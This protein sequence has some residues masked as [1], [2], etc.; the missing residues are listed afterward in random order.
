MDKQWSLVACLVMAL[1]GCA[2]KTSSAP[3]HVDLRQTITLHAGQNV[4]LK[5][6]QKA[7]APE[8]VTLSSGNG[9][10]KITGH[11][12]T[13]KGHTEVTVSVPIDATGP[14]DNL[15]IVMSAPS[16]GTLRA[17]A[18]PDA[19]GRDQ[20]LPESSGFQPSW[21]RIENSFYI[22][23][24]ND[25]EAVARLA[26][27]YYVEDVPEVPAS[28]SLA[29][30]P[31]YKKFLMRSFYADRSMITVFATQDALVIGTASLA[32]PPVSSG[33]IAICL[34]NLPTRVEGMFTQIWLP[35]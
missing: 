18:V 31:G 14:A 16:S 29:C 7:L 21:R 26:G 30:G 1:S 33:A 3:S 22:N 5:S 4:T 11:G 17:A 8:G 27:S 9:E 34:K 20:W 10:F 25:S 35:L 28:H 12:M 15:I 23:L 2:V 6:G 13:L 32:A 24:G 19:F